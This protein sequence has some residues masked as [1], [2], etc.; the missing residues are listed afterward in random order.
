M[1]A[2]FSPFMHC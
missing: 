2:L 1:D